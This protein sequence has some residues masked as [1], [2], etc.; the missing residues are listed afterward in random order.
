MNVFEARQKLYNVK[1][2]VKGYG[3]VKTKVK[4]ATNLDPWGPTGE[5]LHDIC[6]AS[7]HYEDK[8]IIIKA[9][10]KR[11]TNSQVKEWQHIHKALT[12][13]EYLLLHGPETLADDI[14]DQLYNFRTLHDF[15]AIDDKGQDRGVSIRE[16]SKKLVD[17]ITNTSVL[18]EER[19]KAAQRKSKFVGISSNSGGSGF[20]IQRPETEAEKI[21]MERSRWEAMRIDEAPPIPASSVDVMSMA[22]NAEILEQ[23]RAIMEDIERQRRANDAASNPPVPSVAPPTAR[24]SSPNARLRN[25][26]PPQ[27][28]PASHPQTE[29]NLFGDFDTIPAAQQ[30]S[31]APALAPTAPSPHTLTAPEPTGFDPFADP[32]SSPPKAT[33]LNDFFTSPAPATAGSYTAMS[34]ATSASPQQDL[35]SDGTP[36][37]S[38]PTAPVPQSSS[39]IDPSFDSLVSW[40]LSAKPT[41]PSPG[42]QPSL[43]ELKQSHHASPTPAA[44][45]NPFL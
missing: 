43:K 21:E 9:L 7:F 17:W 37:R 24:P 29:P 44:S 12:T 27:S 16:K 45:F 32:V 26:T 18:D 19:A 30:T 35:F 11:L 4:I 6:E 1:A 33:D 5:Q 36:A 8:R 2:T 10:F 14:R 22:E 20:R 40:D 13:F 34:A 38:N 42:S 3:E 25:L 31:P 41:S 23:Q 39:I 15:Q 28:Q